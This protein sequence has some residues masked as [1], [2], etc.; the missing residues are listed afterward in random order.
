M[1][2]YP[3]SQRK[4]DNENSISNYWLFQARR[5][6]ENAFGLLSQKFQNLSEDPTIIAGECGQHYF[7]DLYFA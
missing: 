1:R 3:G 7:C 6:V 2:P 5:V 4:W